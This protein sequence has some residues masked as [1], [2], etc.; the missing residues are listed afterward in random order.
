MVEWQLRKCMKRV[1]NV[2]VPGGGSTVTKAELTSKQVTGLHSTAA[3]WAAS[4][5]LFLSEMPP[6]VRLAL[7][8]RKEKKKSGQFPRSHGS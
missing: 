5:S 4:R 3:R 6:F 1:S 2:C 7:F 8:H